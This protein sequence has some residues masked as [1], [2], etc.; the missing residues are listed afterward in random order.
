M[1]GI[2]RT[3]RSSVHLIKHV[4]ILL[5]L[6]ENITARGHRFGLVAILGGFEVVPAGADTGLP[7]GPVS[8]GKLG[9]KDTIE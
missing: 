2:S 7:A 9:T 4:E 1:L 5:N 6:A 8:A 3:G